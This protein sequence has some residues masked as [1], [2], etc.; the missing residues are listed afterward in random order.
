MCDLAY[1]LGLLRRGNIA[2]PSNQEGEKDVMTPTYV[3]ANVIPRTK[4]EPYGTLTFTNAHIKPVD[5]ARAADN[6]AEWRKYLPEDCVNAMVK[7]GW[8]RTV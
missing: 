3:P 8:H 6:I 4:G 5:S 2:G 7:A 1:R